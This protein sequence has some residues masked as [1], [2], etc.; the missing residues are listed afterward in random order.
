MPKNVDNENQEQIE[1]IDLSSLE[2][3]LNHKFKDIDLLRTALTHASAISYYGNPEA[4]TQDGHYYCYEQLEFLGDRVLGLVIADLLYHLFPLETEG[5][6]A[7][8]H[9]EAVKEFTLYLVAE[10]LTLG[11]YLLLST[12]EQRTGG[13][14][15]KALLSDAM[16]A[17][18]AAIYMDSDFETAKE[19]ISQHWTKIIMRDTNPPEDP[20]TKLQEWLQAQGKDLPEYKLVSRSGPDHLPVFEVSVIIDCMEPVTAKDSSKRKAEKKAA[21]ELLK[22]IEKNEENENNESK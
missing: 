1:L 18:I 14:R 11:D 9:T 17:V 20:K 5:D 4:R 8:R 10:T 16:E 21:T 13:R 12:A 6:W 15:K 22:I 19:F 7:K 3:K 2:E